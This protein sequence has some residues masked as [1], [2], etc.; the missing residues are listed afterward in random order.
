MNCGQAGKL[1]RSGCAV[2]WIKTDETKKS[3]E[4]LEKWSQRTQLRLFI[5]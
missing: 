1:E 3:L 5:D 4:E 2:G